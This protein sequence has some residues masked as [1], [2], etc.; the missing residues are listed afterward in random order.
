MFAADAVNVTEVALTY[1][2]IVVERDGYDK[3]NVAPVPDPD[4]EDWATGFDG[5]VATMPEVVT[6]TKATPIT[7]ESVAPL[8]DPGA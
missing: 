8:N 5:I 4:E 7:R 6:L 3:L 1:D 2:A